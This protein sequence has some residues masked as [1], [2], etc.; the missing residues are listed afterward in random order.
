[1]RARV[2]VRLRPG[3]LDPQGAAV[4]EALRALGFPV[5]DV[6]VGKVLDI[7]LA[8]GGGDEARD[9]CRQM[10]ERLLANPVLE[11][12]AVEVDAP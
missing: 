8:A 6:R 10:A 11:T 7:E 2:T 3:V 4:R 12:F 5:E 9:L 1:V